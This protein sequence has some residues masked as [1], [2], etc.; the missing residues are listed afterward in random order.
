MPKSFLNKVAGLRPDS[1]TTV[2]TNED[3]VLTEVKET[4]IKENLTI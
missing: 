4:K 3:I 1:V 2:L